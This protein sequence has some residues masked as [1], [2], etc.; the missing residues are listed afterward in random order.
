MNFLKYSKVEDALFIWFQQARLSNIPIS[1]P[2]LQGK[3]SMFALEFGI[4]KFQASTGWLDK[5]KTSRT[6]R[7]FFSLEFSPTTYNSLTSVI[8][9]K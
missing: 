5:F 3:A 2:I 6:S 1:G 7:G 9:I 8:S 4:V